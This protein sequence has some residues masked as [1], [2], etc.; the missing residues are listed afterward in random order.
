M[1]KKHAY[2]L[3]EEFGE[4]KAVKDLRSVAAFY[5]KGIPFAKPYKVDMCK[6]ESIK[7]LEDIL[8][9]VRKNSKEL[10]E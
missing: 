2:L 1:C 5:M 4:N 10:E 6:I 9:L 7:E 3:V 8:E